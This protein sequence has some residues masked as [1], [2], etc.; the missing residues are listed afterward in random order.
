MSEA[1]RRRGAYP[2]A[3]GRPFTPEENA[4]LGT[5]ID[6]EIGERIGRD[7]KTVQARRKRLGI[8]AFRWNTT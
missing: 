1:Q 5:A 3:A 6:R 8:V 7:Y 2:P 4:L